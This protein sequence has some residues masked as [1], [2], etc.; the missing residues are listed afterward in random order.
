MTHPH[1]GIDAPLPHP[2]GDRARH[3]QRKR[4]HGTDLSP[5]KG[6]GKR[7]KGT[8]NP[9][10]MNGHERRLSG[11]KWDNSQ[12]GRGLKWDNTQV[13][14]G[15][16]WDNTQVGRGLKWDWYFTGVRGERGGYAWRSCRFRRS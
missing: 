11:F 7:I 14:R 9:S 16:K 8:R 15:L 4:R 13:G 5:K 10:K 6:T 1:T 12:V 3:L 2:H